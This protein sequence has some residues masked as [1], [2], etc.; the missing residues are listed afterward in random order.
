MAAAWTLLST[1]PAPYNNTAP[2]NNQGAHDRVVA[3]TCDAVEHTLSSVHFSGFESGAAKKPDA[4]DGL[5]DSFDSYPLARSASSHTEGRVLAS[6]VVLFRV[7]FPVNSGVNI[8]DARLQWRDRAGFTPASLFI[9][10]D[11]GIPF[12]S[13]ILLKKH[14]GLSW[15]DYNR[16]QYPS[17]RFIFVAGGV[18][19]RQYLPDLRNGRAYR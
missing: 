4:S 2:I 1:Y 11:S 14:R 18:L 5:I 19:Q 13:F 15:R 10:N 8:R 9:P 6:G 3:D 16:P 17:Q 12:R 7:P